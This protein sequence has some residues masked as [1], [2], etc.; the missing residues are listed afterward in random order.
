MAIRKKSTK[1]KVTRAAAPRRRKATATAAP[2]RRK[3]SR[4]L[5]AAS[6]AVIKSTLMDMAMGAAGAAAAMF[7]SNQ[8]FL[9]AQSETNKGLIIAGVGVATAVFLKQPRIATGMGAVAGLKLLQGL[10]AGKLV[11][12]SEM[13]GQALFPISESVPTAL[14]PY[15]LEEM[16]DYANLSEASIYSNN[17]GSNYSGL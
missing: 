17:Y 12:L 8:K 13:N 11:G 15:G 16:V 1:R 7:L 4:S 6:P 10:G 9:D 2:R 5:R 14:I 3:M